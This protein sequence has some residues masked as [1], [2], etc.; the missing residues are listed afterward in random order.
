MA[1]PVRLAEEAVYK[2]LPAFPSLL[3]GNELVNRFPMLRKQILPKCTH[4]QIHLKMF[5]L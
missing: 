5:D 4:W 3:S 2:H 1:H